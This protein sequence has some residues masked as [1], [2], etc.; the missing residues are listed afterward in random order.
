MRAQ[1]DLLGL[2]EDV[3]MCIQG[4]LEEGLR[5]KFRVTCGNHYVASSTFFKI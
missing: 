3:Q 2:V 4:V 5:W 1:E